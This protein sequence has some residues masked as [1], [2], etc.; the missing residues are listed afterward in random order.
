MVCAQVMGNDAAVG[1][2]GSHG[3][4]QLNVFKPVM[5]YNL[6][7]SANLL[8]DAMDSFRE[9][10]VVGIQPNEDRIKSHLDNSLMLVTALNTHVG[11]YKA[12]EIAQSA[13][14]RDTTLRQAAIELGYLTGEEFDR[15]VVPE[16]MVGRQS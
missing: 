13:H 11:Y 2:A 7:M 3:H 5:I 1:V 12:A 15:L 6:L 9:K 8:A 4:L 16:E 10:C 14:N